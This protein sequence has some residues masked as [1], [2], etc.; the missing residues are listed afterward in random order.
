MLL[1]LVFTS[2]SSS[3]ARSF[4]TERLKSS[5][6]CRSS[7]TL[8]ALLPIVVFVMTIGLMRLVILAAKENA[9]FLRNLGWRRCLRVGR[10]RLSI[11]HQWPFWRF[12]IYGLTEYALP[13][14][15]QHQLFQDNVLIYDYG[16]DLRDNVLQST[17][18]KFDDKIFQFHVDVK[19]L[20]NEVSQENKRIDL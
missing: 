10:R 13:F 12:R 17:A 6:T 19:I 3:L 8:K 20:E 15:A 2:L 7:S 14:Y 5:N 11:G 16:H 1:A 9:Y 4:T 18:T